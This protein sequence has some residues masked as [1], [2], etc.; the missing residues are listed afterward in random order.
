MDCS[1]TEASSQTDGI[2][3]RAP[4]HENEATPRLPS[5]SR[6]S[7]RHPEIPWQIVGVIAD[8]KINGLDD[9]WSAGMYVPIAQSP[10]EYVSLVV[11]GDVSP[12][13]MQPAPMLAHR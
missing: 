11:K 1:H 10:T 7:V 2:V 6:R 5:H 3:T 4:R 13:L 8:E 9:N 12:E